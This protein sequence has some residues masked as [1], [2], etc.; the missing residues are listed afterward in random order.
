MHTKRREDG[1]RERGDRSKPESFASAAA[2][3]A[4]DFDRVRLL[5]PPE[6]R[7]AHEIYRMVAV[8]L[9]ADRRGY[10]LGDVPVLAM[11]KADFAVN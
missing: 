2:V 3:R 4:V 9:P 7:R 6:A 8:P 11:K 10:R 5:E 1:K